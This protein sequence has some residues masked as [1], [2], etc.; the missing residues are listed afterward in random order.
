MSVGYCH[1]LSFLIR[2]L[3]FRGRQHIFVCFHDDIRF[4]TFAKKHQCTSV[5]RRLFLISRKSDKIL[6]IRILGQ[7]LNKFSVR[8]LIFCLYNQ[9]T[10]RQTKWLCN[11]SVFAFE[12]SR[13]FPLELF[14]GIEA[15]ILIHLLIGFMLHPN[16]WLK[17]RK[18]L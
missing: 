17:R 6:I 7:L 16:G 11:I 8:I 4:H 18:L 9:R 14:H 1:H 2:V 3:F 12:Q 5:N 10:K 15:A 13:I